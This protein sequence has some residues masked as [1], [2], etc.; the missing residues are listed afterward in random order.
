MNEIAIE[1]PTRID[2]P[3]LPPASQDTFR[4]AAFGI[5]CQ[6]SFCHP[7][8]S[9]YVPGADEDAGRTVAWIR[10]NVAKITTLVFSLDTHSVHQVFHPAAWRDREG[11]PPAPFTTISSREVREGRWIP[12]IAPRETMVEYCERLEIGGKYRLT[13]W[14][15]HVLQGGVGHALLPSILEAALYHSFARKTDPV[16][17]LKGRH[18]LTENFSVLSPEV[19]E[20]GGRK[21]GEFNAKFLEVLDGYDRIY[22]FGQAKSHCVLSTLQD[23]RKLRNKIRVLEDAM[24]CVPGFE[25]ATE[26]AFRGLGMRLMRTTDELD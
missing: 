19:T 12:T 2:A 22:V 24:S 11:R 17:E 18:A 8:G 15:Y 21:I 1:D 5:D 25:T 26:R 20:L 14:P 13:I 4:V 16:F 7:K 9:L 10:R 23:L 6:I 3:D